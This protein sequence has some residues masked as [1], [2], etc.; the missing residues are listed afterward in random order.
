MS[1]T[2]RPIAFNAVASFAI[3]LTLEVGSRWIWPTELPDPFITETDANW[4]NTRRYDPLLFWSLRPSSSGPRLFTNRLGLRGP[5]IPAKTAGEFRILSLGESTTFAGRLPYDQSYSSLLERGL[6]LFIG[7]IVRVINA[8]V[9]GYTLF[10]GVVYLRERGLALEPDA[11]LAYFGY[12]DF[13]PVV[14]REQRDAGSARSVAGLTDRE[15]FEQRSRPARRAVEALL[16]VSNLARAIAFRS[17]PEPSRVVTGRRVRVP[18]ADRRALLAELRALGRAH[19]VRVAVIIPWYRSFEKHAPLLRELHGASDVVLID[20][21]SLL[22]D[23]P[24]LRSAY[25]VDD[26]HPNAEGHQLIA[27]AIERRLRAEWTDP[28][29]D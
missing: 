3:L 16:G 7:G 20:L 21:P 1:R 27:D 25:F 10:Q 17:S 13:L 18:E 6:G 2:I 12:N 23:V 15:L 28:Q 4:R 19:G 11:I 9:P 14:H 29:P 26:V 24:K 8:G 5:E 22:S